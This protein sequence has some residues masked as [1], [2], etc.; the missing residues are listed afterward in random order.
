MDAYCTE[1]KNSFEIINHIQVIFFKREDC[2]QTFTVHSSYC[3]FSAQVN[4]D[5]L[6]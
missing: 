3:R 4:S 5:K 1:K 6:I 2:D